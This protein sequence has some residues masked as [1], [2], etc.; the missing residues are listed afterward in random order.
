MRVPCASAMPLLAQKLPSQSRSTGH[1]QDSETPA[2]V[3]TLLTGI[4]FVPRCADRAGLL[5]YP[6]AA[7]GI[8]FIL[9][10][11]ADTLPRVALE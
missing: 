9:A 2:Q 1:G 10:L 6:L 7:N 4:S 11:V 3:R 8:Y 5:A